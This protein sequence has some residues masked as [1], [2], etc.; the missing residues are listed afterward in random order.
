VPLLPTLP[1]FA[2]FSAQ[3]TAQGIVVSWEC[4]ATANPIKD[5][6]HLFRIYRR[7]ESHSGETRIAEI[8]V[9]G[10]VAGTGTGKFLDQTFEWEQTYF[11]RGTVVS[12]LEM[13]G[14]PPTEVEGEDTPEVKAFAHDIFPPAVPS[15]V[16]AVNSGTGQQ[17]F[18]DLIWTP[19]SDADLD[20]YNVYRHEEG[21]APAKINTQLVKM[22]A[23]RDTQ[24][25]SGRTYFYSASAVDQRGNESA[26]SEEASERVP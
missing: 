22:P 19:V 2:S 18:I 20:G 16:Q 21:T 11:Y 14:K 3:V 4:P 15:G 5:I 17:P 10:C 23:Y 8:D 25:E 7:A 12:A 9:T 13:R 1:P 26:R 6:K 24:V